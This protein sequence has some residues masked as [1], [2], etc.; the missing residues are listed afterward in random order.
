M[1]RRR[2]TAVR[3]RGSSGDAAADGPM[4]RRVEFRKERGSNG[5]SIPC[6][7]RKVSTM[8][9]ITK[10]TIPASC[11]AGVLFIGFAIGDGAK[12][13]NGG[14]SQSIAQA[15]EKGRDANCSERTI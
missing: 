4:G 5:T 3:P 12:G 10:A 11:L 7:K 14:A 8:K 2:A 6:R 15:Q 1:A 13:D 9:A